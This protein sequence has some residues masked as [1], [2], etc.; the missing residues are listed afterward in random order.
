MF[1][2]L[3][4]LEVGNFTSLAYTGLR[5]HPV[6][7]TKILKQIQTIV[8]L[9]KVSKT[10]LGICSISLYI[11]EMENVISWEKS[12]KKKNTIWEIENFLS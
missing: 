3:F 12:K 2:N 10:V 5:E 8:Q 9:K 11:F 1:H 4:C 7:L 6:R